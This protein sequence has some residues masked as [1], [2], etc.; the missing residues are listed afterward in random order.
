MASRLANT[1][2]SFASTLISVYTWHMKM[3]PAVRKFALAAHVIFS[4]GWLGAVLAYLPLAI[5]GLT[6][7]DVQTVRAS[8]LSME[9]IAWFAILPCCLGGLLT[10][11]V[12]SLGTEWG[13]FRHY[14]VALKFL[15]TLTGTIVLLLHMPTITRV[16]RMAAEMTLPIASPGMVQRQLVIHAAGGLIVLLAA[17]I[18]SI[19]KPW[20]LTPYGKWRMSQATTAPSARVSPIR[21]SWRLLALIGFIGLLIMVIILHL[22]GGGFP[23]H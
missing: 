22:I 7:A 9:T 10:G 5:T 6:S 8:Y 4:V 16:A 15:L 3:T 13:L 12:Q 14:W 23:H 1:A 11:L 19:Y 20:G 18:L 17:T 2:L 21:I